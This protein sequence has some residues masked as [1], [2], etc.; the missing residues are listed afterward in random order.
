ALDLLKGLAADSHPRV[1]L[2]A[3]RAASFFR[4]AA[5]AEVALAAVNHPLDYY[6]EYTLK[7]TM[8]Q[9]QK[10]WRPAL[11][12]GRPLAAGNPA[13]AEYLVKSVT[14]PEL[15]KLPRSPGILSAILRRPDASD[16]DR[17]AALSDL[18]A[19]RQVARAAALLDLVEE[20]GRSNDESA[21]ALARLLASQAPA[22]LKTFRTRLAALARDGQSP[23]IRSAAWASLAVADDDFAAVWSEAG[24]SPAALTELL[25]GVPL[26]LD[27]A[28]RARLNE[29]LRPLL[30]DLPADLQARLQARPAGTGRYVRV[31]LPRN[32]TLTLA[33]V[34]VFSGERNVGRQGRATQSSTSNGGDASRA[35]DGNTDGSFGN[36]GQTHTA[37][38]QANPWWEVDLGQEFPIDAVQVW[39]RTEGQLGK[40]LD[41]FKLSVLDA[42]RRPVFEKAGQPAPD[43]KVRLAVGGDPAGALRRAAIRALVSASQ[44]TPAT[45]AALGALVRRGEQVPAAAS[46]LRA[47][48]RPDW[49]R[50]QAADVARGIVTWARTVPADARTTPEVVEA[51]QLA[52]DLAGLASADAGQALRRDLKELR[53]AVFV[54][55][56]VREQ[57]RYDVTRLVVEAGKPFEIVFEN[58]DFMP[59]NLV[60]VK[61]GTR[62]KVGAAAALMTPDQRDGQGRPYVPRGDDAWAGSR[63][64]DGGQQQVLK[65]KAPDAEGVHEFVCTFPGHWMSMWGQ[66][67]VTKDVEAYLAAHPEAP[68]I[69]PTASPEGP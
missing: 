67:V 49:P 13:G 42:G 65:L 43:V 52:T 46:G 37:E 6:L 59:H 30:G 12:A 22:E 23:A 41:G 40:R 57:M 8:R 34:E 7:E 28:L 38:N 62:E 33:E 61:P 24:R 11:A 1:R 29:R 51:I 31:E 16:L 60:M 20:A 27:A 58:A 55:R 54:I 39:N 2:E 44:D 36:N 14:T 15:L 17:T 35:L 69:L 18:A 19:S 9:L 48:P 25:N 10:Y 32:G 64:I 68:W 4:D 63:L 5:A 47:L 50:A 26:I 53:V 3:V 21:P 66:L 56:T 45:F